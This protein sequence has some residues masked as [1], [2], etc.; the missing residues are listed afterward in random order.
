L[1]SPVGTFD[2]SIQ[3]VNGMLVKKGLVPHIDFWSMYTPLNYYINT[4]SFSLFGESVI[5]VRIVQII[6]Y[7]ISIV[8]LS[9]YFKNF[10][11][12]NENKIYKTLVFPLSLVSSVFLGSMLIRP[13]S[14]AYFLCFIGLIIYLLSF[15]IPNKYEIQLLLL[16]GLFLGLGC[17]VKLNFGLYI[18][19]AILANFVYESIWLNKLRG[20]R[21]NFYK[22]FMFTLP[23]VICFL[24]YLFSY[25]ENLGILIDQVLIFPSHHLEAH[26]IMSLT[27]KSILL[28]I[29]PFIYFSLRSNFFVDK[30]F[31]YQLFLPIS[32]T[33]ILFIIIY[34]SNINAQ[35]FLPK[36]SIIIFVL[37]ILLQ[38]FINSL[39]R[40]ELIILLCYSLFTHYFFS[41]SDDFHYHPV[42][43]LIPLLIP[44]CLLITDNKSKRSLFK[45]DKL[46]HYITL[47]F[48]IILLCKTSL[49][50]PSRKSLLAT[51]SNPL[52]II[53]LSRQ[54]DSNYLMKTSFPLSQIGSQ[55]YPDKDELMALKFVHDQTSSHDSVYIGLL[56]HSQTYANNMRSYWILNRSIG[57]YAHELE[58]GL[59]TE[60]VVQEEMIKDLESNQVI[61]IILNNSAGEGDPDFQK[62]NYV[63]STLLDDY[64]KSRYSMVS[65][66]GEYLIFKIK[67]N[68]SKNIN[69]NY[70]F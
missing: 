70:Y 18:F 55:L 11:G 16:A 15:H 44:S 56:D 58:P 23:I 9:I 7:L 66:F 35:N 69:F 63:G 43:S 34:W 10:S 12:V 47:T 36:L 49:G 53:Q 28:G 13:Y 57:V 29:F 67:T 32:I 8:T 62:R 50:L 20:W 51:L 25:R 68:Q 40:D 14:N 30:R 37:L 42:L 46:Q 41:R 27:S 60:K 19:T 3:L 52:G 38:A 45:A 48:L 31:N 2:E 1:V 39:T 61:W 5:S 22:I 54:G 24:M 64:I 21:I 59:T 17:L 65:K 4:L 6:F 26:R 33:F